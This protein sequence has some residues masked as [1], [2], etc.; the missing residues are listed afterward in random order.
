MRP[1][2]T[3]LAAILLLSLGLAASASAHTPDISTARLTPKD[4]GWTVEVGFLAT[5]L[6]R[7][8]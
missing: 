8:F 6:E 5:D 7:M 1:L 4:G 2:W 3:R